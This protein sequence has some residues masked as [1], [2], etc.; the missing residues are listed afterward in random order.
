MT[1]VLKI[2]IA[3]RTIVLTVTVFHEQVIMREVEEIKHIYIVSRD[4]LR[5]QAKSLTPL[6]SRRTAAHQQSTPTREGPSSS[7]QAFQSPEL[8]ELC[9]P[10]RC[11]DERSQPSR[12]VMRIFVIPMNWW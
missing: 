8:R 12:D 5:T 9:E 3:P 2:R 1:S 6:Q 11:C 10:I 7:K 4:M